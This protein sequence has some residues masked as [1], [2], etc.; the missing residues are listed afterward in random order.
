[1]FKKAAYEGDEELNYLAQ[2]YDNEGNEI[3]R[4]Q[5]H[6]QF[7]ERPYLDRFPLI[8]KVHPSTGSLIAIINGEVRYQVAIQ[9]D[10]E[11][12]WDISQ[13]EILEDCLA[14]VRSKYGDDISIDKQPFFS[15]LDLGISGSASPMNR[16]VSG[17][18]Y[19]PLLMP[20]TKISTLQAPTSSSIS[21]CL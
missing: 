10:L 13:K 19:C 17:K 18:I 9:T 6:A 5:Y 20:C 3:Y 16:W 2:A 15:L 11:R 21:D 14:F 4:D 7:S 8:G 12:I 1:M